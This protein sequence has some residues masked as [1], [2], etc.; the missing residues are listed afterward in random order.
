MFD[1]AMMRVLT[2]SSYSSYCEKL[3]RRI[4]DPAIKKY[5]NKGLIDK[6]EKDQAKKEGWKKKALFK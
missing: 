4:I 1:I 6:I 3:G 2:Y 5:E